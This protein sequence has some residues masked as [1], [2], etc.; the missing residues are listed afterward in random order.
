MQATDEDRE[1]EHKEAFEPE[2]EVSLSTTPTTRKELWAYYLY[3]VGNNGLPAWY[4]GPAQFQNLLHR[5]GYDPTQAPFTTAC[6]GNGCV[7]PYLGS[8]RDGAS[9]TRLRDQLPDETL[10][11]VE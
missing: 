4:F 6:N 2:T 3:L 7:L 11:T 8:V 5:A 10:T 9:F 1:S